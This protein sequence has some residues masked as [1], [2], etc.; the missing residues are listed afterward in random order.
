MPIVNWNNRFII[1]VK[2]FDEHH[3]HLVGLLNQ[4][5]DNFTAGADSKS[6][7]MILDEL[8]NYATYHFATEERWMLENSYPNFYGHRAEHDEFTNRVAEMIKSNTNKD[9]NL[10]LEVMT[11]LNDWITQ[12]ILKVDI[13]YG[14][15]ISAKGLPINLA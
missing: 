15:Y 6:T 11:F 12:H 7:D 5:H 4:A 3:K 14:I 2:Q 1:G 8:V 13:E 10:L 9:D